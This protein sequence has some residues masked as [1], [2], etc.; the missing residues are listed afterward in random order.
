MSPLNSVSSN[1]SAE[2]S[3]F[4]SRLSKLSKLQ[5]IVIT[6]NPCLEGVVGTV[7]LAYLSRVHPTHIRLIREDIC[8]PCLDESIMCAPDYA[9]ESV[10]ALTKRLLTGLER[11]VG[12]KEITRRIVLACA[13]DAPDMPEIVHRY[14]RLAFLHGADAIEDIANSTVAEFN[15]LA[16][17]VETE[18]EHTRQFV[19]FSRMSD[20]SFMSVFQPNANVI[21]L[22]CNYFVKRMSVERFFIVDPSHKVV[23]FHTP[24]MKTFS[25]IQLDDTSM[26]EILSRTNLATDE[27][28]IQAMWKCFYEGIS[29]EGRSPDERGY[30]LRAHWMPKRIWQGLPELTANINTARSRG[31]PVRYQG[32]ESKRNVHK[33]LGPH[34]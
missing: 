15:S 25:T 17:N 32:H 7:G 16:R 19:R 31:I 30:D 9:D 14:I 1:Q 26:K 2:L 22:T 3:L 27:C 24:E 34:S 12:T 23:S 4:I 28:Y 10:V 6:C 20:G 18:R 29:L 13:S 8:Q 21:P 11:K 33:F 5:K